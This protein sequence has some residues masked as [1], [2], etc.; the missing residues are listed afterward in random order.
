M[1]SNTYIFYTRGGHAIQARDV[2]GLSLSKDSDGR[3]SGCSIKW[4]E[5]K[6]PVFFSLNIKEIVAV[7]CPDPAVKS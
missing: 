4:V 6:T 1:A 2:A 5:G 3:F 7:V